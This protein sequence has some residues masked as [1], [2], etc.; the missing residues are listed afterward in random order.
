MSKAPLVSF[1]TSCAK[2]NT[3]TNMEFVSVLVLLLMAVMT[4]SWLKGDS[5][6]STSFSVL[7]MPSCSDLSDW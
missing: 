5:D 6:A 4:D 3:S 1:D 7:S 2:V